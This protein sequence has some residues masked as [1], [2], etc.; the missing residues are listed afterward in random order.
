MKFNKN[1]SY[2]QLSFTYL[3]QKND[4]VTC[5]KN[6]FKSKD[7]REKLKFQSASYLSSQC[8]ERQMNVELDSKVEKFKFKQW[9]Q[10]VIMDARITHRCTTA[11]CNFEGSTRMKRI[12]EDTR[13]YK[14]MTLEDLELICLNRGCRALP[15]AKHYQPKNGISEAGIQKAPVLHPPFDVAVIKGCSKSKDG[16]P[17]EGNK[18]SKGGLEACGILFQRMGMFYSQTSKQEKN[19]VDVKMKG[20]TKSTNMRNPYPKSAVLCFPW[21][22]VLL[23]RSAK[24]KKK[25]SSSH[26]KMVASSSR[27]AVDPINSEFVYNAKLLL[28]FKC[29]SKPTRSKSE[30]NPTNSDKMSKSVTSLPRD[31]KCTGQVVQALPEEPYCN[32][33]VGQTLTSTPIVSNK[34]G[35]TVKASKID[36]R[37]EKNF[38]TNITKRRS[39][40][41]VPAPGGLR[42]G[43][44]WSQ[45][46]TSAQ[47]G[48]L[49]QLDYQAET[50]IGHTLTPAEKVLLFDRFSPEYVLSRI[51]QVWSF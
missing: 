24:A 50:E 36:E 17:I 25:K 39:G 51:Q 5:V 18:K 11:A 26:Y 2:L 30:V 8:S 47:I 31:P 44:P 9:Q 37:N 3:E 15:C 10:K 41:K 13:K 33:R 43:H 40:W 42:G 49:Q 21:K 46:N 23:G 22:K 45:K 14:L 48:V 35:F 1:I 20:A 29:K 12:M 19:V 16:V 4:S 6:P 34:S 38:F 28:R 7:I 27:P 32:K